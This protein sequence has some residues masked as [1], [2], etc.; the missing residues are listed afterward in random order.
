MF[1][2]NSEL[3]SSEVFD[4]FFGCIIIKDYFQSTDTLYQS[5]MIINIT[6]MEIASDLDH[7]RKLTLFY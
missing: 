1:T 2:V 3:K 4:I 6:P 7:G 5:G